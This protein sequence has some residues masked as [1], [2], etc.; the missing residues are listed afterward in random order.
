[1]TSNL[2]VHGEDEADCSI[3]R[4]TQDKI[5]SDGILRICPDHGNCCNCLDRSHDTLPWYL[6]G[7]AILTCMCCLL[8]SN[9]AH[10]GQLTGLLRSCGSLAK[11]RVEGVHEAFAGGSNVLFAQLRSTDLKQH[12]HRACLHVLSGLERI[13][14]SALLY[15]HS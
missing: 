1:M 7:P 15:M 9:G 4:A 13:C 6:P 5:Y 12:R 10:T 8:A 14:H 3:A 11:V 2:R